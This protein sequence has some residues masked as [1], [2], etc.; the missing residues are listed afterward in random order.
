MSSIPNVSGISFKSNYI[1]PF[2]QVKDS[3]TMRAIG[4]V[5]CTPKKVINQ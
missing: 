4:E 2:D 3:A 5:K 1:I